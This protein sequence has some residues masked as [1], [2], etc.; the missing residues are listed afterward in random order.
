MAIIVNRKATDITKFLPNLSSPKFPHPIFLPTLKLGPTIRTPE[1]VE[2]P[3]SR[4]QCALLCAMDLVVRCRLSFSLLEW[5]MI[6]RSSLWKSS[7]SVYAL[8]STEVYPTNRSQRKIRSSFGAIFLFLMY[9][10]EMKN[11]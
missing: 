9:L 8:F 6:L 11:H 4:E 2:E 7:H 5:S 10:Q 1:D 3:G